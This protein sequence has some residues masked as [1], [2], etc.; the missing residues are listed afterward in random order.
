MT[1]SD[2]LY[3]LLLKLPKKNLVNLLWESLDEMQSY[4]GNTKTYCICKALGFK[5]KEENGRIIFE[6]IDLSEMKKN[7]D[8]MG[9]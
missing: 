2:K 6:E 5:E 4:N 7:T 3:E 9:F 1:M 8:T